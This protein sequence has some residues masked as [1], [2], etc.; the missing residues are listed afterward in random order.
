[1]SPI[2]RYITK[3]F[4]SSL[5]PPKKLVYISLSNDI[6]A[7]LALE[8]WLFRNVS[9]NDQHL[10]LIWRN[11]PC[12]VIGTFQNPWLETNP[13]L[14]P[15]IGNG[16]SLARRRSGGGAVF[17][18]QGNLNLTFF[19][20]VK[21]YNR[22][23]NLNYIKHVLE[24]RHNIRLDITPK[25]DLMLGGAKVSGSAAKIGLHSAY[26]HCSLLID[27]DKSML[28][29]ALEGSNFEIKTN[30]TKSAPSG[31]VNLREKNPS[32][33]VDQLIKSIAEEYSTST[34]SFE[35]VNPEES[36]YQG[37]EVLKNTFKSWHWLYGRS[38]KF[39]VSLNCDN[40]GEIEMVIEGGIISEFNCKSKKHFFEEF[41]G[42]KFDQN[43]LLISEN[44][45]SK[46][47]LPENI[48]CLY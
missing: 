2:L 46:L 41:I 42:Q 32:I 13:T 28:N 4:F 11:D 8:D 15:K 3:R 33:S 20:N 38:P 48:G 21:D 43:I 29:S 6:Y 19:T 12:V 34:E 35:F 9:F 18:D 45:R 22:R 5:V 30:A 17:H 14:L 37:I 31:V 25:C 26:H 16:V 24:K 23:R 47:L 7:N 40:F 10:L 36:C 39:L 44:Y 1:M 27:V